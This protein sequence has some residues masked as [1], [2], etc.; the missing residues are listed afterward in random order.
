MDGKIALE[1]HFAIEDTLGDSQKFM[2]ADFWRVLKGR[3]LDIQDKRLA[4]MDAH[5]IERNILSLNAPA[6]QAIRDPAEAA[7]VA[8]IANDV[9][10]EEV[11][12][13]PDRFSGFAALPMQDPEAAARELQRCVR[14]FGFKGA[15]VNGFSETTADNECL[16]YDLPRYRPFWA[17]V[18]A[19]GVPFYLHPREPLPSQALIYEGHPWLTGPTWAFA[20]ETAVHAMRLMASGLFDEH[21]K[22]TVILGHL[23]EALPYNLWRADHRIRRS[24]RGYPAKRGMGDYFRENFFITTSGN[25]HDQTLIQAVLELGADRILFSTDY[26]FEEVDEAANW[27]DRVPIAENDKIKIGRTNA[28]RLFGFD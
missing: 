5:G 7:K 27:F 24:P 3:L 2:P 23:G 4:L 6:I 22:L 16:Y 25:C 26:P 17:A 28:A 15:L 1:E 12:K 18:E 13:R 11:A 19:L 9:L 8:R 14:D 20:Q 21:P 10:A